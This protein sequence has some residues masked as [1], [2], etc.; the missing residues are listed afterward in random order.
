[1]NLDPIQT[2]I[3]LCRLRF[4]CRK[5][6]RPLGI[7]RGFRRV[8]MAVAVPKRR[9]SRTNDRAGKTHS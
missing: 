3:V 2:W 9:A 8:G 1:M 5:L 7:R 4:R 6:R